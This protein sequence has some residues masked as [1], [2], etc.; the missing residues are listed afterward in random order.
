MHKIIYL[1]HINSDYADSLLEMLAEK[2]F[3]NKPI[4]FVAD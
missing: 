1:T 4:F 3:A 2:K